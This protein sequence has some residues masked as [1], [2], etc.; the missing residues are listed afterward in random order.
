MRLYNEAVVW[1]PNHSKELA[2]AF[3][4]RSAVQFDN[5]EFQ[6]ALQDIGSALAGQSYPSKL[7]YKLHLRKAFCY[8]ELGQADKARVAFTEAFDL[9]GDTDILEDKTQEIRNLIN[10]AI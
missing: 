1:A 9:A 2:M 6:A 8:K 7:R 4:N 3:A 10:D 5:G